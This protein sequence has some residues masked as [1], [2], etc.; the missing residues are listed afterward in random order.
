METRTWRARKTLVDERNEVEQ[1]LAAARADIR[2]H[3]AR[4]AQLN[5]AI[6]AEDDNSNSSEG[7]MRHRYTVETLKYGQGGA[8]QD[9][10]N[11]VRVTFETD[12]Q[13]ALNK[14]GWEKSKLS[15]E[16]VR[17]MLPNLRC[18]FTDYVYN[19]KVDN[20]MEAAFRRR[21]DWLKEIEPGVWE[22]HTTDRHT[23]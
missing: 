20:S 17:D 4:L 7:N 8:Y 15:E 14:N 13:G 18:G 10:V 21:L 5:A 12:F 16:S 1:Y 9:S 6:R 3:E 22:F 19:P 23:D 2:Q 11:H